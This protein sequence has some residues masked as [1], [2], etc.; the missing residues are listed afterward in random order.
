MSCMQSDNNNHLIALSIITLRYVHCIVNNITNAKH[1]EIT[2]FLYLLKLWWF[3]FVYLQNVT[4]IHQSMSSLWSCTFWPCSFMQCHSIRC[5]SQNWVEKHIVRNLIVVWKYNVFVL[6][7]TSM[8]CKN[9]FVKHWIV[10]VWKVNFVW[11]NTLLWYHTRMHHKL[12]LNLSL[13]L[14]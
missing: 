6:H 13:F 2:L 11:Q 3:T 9:T 4:V 8:W 14:I 12:N 10:V 7:N 1:T 5:D